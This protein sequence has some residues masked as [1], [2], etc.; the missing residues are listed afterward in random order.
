MRAFI[1]RP[2]GTKKDLKGNDLDFNK[3]SEDLIGPAL[4]KVA[5]DGRESPY[6]RAADLDRDRRGTSDLRSV[7]TFESKQ[8]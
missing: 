5:A 4:A 8:G 2:F 3:V 6:R 7:K 1:I